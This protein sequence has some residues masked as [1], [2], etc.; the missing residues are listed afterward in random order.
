MKQ[1]QFNELKFDKFVAPTLDDLEA[2]VRFYEAKSDKDA[3]DQRAGLLM[4]ELH[5]QLRQKCNVPPPSNSHFYDVDLPFRQAFFFYPC[6]QDA[7]EKSNG[8]MRS[9]M[10]AQIRHTMTGIDIEYWANSISLTAQSF[11][12]LCSTICLQKITKNGKCS[13]FLF[14]QELLHTLFQVI[15]PLPTLDFVDICKAMGSGLLSISANDL[16]QSIDSKFFRSSVYAFEQ[17]RIQ[18]E[19]FSSFKH[20]KRKEIKNMSSEEWDLIIGKNEYTVL[21]R[22]I[23]LLIQKQDGLMPLSWVDKLATQIISTAASWAISEC[24]ETT[25]IRLIE[26][27]ILNDTASFLGVD[28][29]LIK[30]DVRVEIKQIHEGMRQRKV[31]C[32]IGSH[33]SWL[34][35]SGFINSL[36]MV[37]EQEIQVSF[38]LYPLNNKDEKLFVGSARCSVVRSLPLLSLLSNPETTPL[39]SHVTKSDIGILHEAREYIIVQFVSI[40][41]NPKDRKSAEVLNTSKDCILLN[42]NEKC[43]YR[44]IDT[45]RTHSKDLSSI[46]TSHVAEAPNFNF[47]LSPNKDKDR[48]DLAETNATTENFDMMTDL[49]VLEEPHK[50][51][52]VRSCSFQLHYYKTCLLKKFVP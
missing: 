5:Q 42:E 1:A 37:M 22:Q 49:Y 13:R 20:I 50:Y 52:K 4:H 36:G 34:D 23:T 39:K 7:T 11:K 46:K 10:A 21:L 47:N 51:P 35:Q 38:W 32:H 17:L 28:G 8:S 26:Q 24:A 48:P 14:P 30:G 12:D 2:P 18:E 31:R 19:G 45:S 9:Y 43:K 6:L 27:V 29:E 15:E 33:Y 40:N 3:D 44:S 25:V 16:L 41:Q